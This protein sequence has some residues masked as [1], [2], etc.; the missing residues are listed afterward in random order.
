MEAARELTDAIRHKP[1]SLHPLPPNSETTQ[2][3]S[4]LAE[5]FTKWATQTSPPS[6]PPSAPLPRVQ[7]HVE[8]PTTLPPVSTLPRSTPSPPRVPN[9]DKPTPPERPINKNNRDTLLPPHTKTASKPP[10]RKTSPY[11]HPCDIAKS[12]RQVPLRRPTHNRNTRAATHYNLQLINNVLDPTTGQQQN[13]K[14]LIAPNSPT[15]DIWL[16]SMGNEIG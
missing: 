8:P 5:I 7:Q 4:K 9:V 13:Y 3:I 1:N 16:Q 6:S 2:A 14:Q 12:Y 11:Y 10:T 15:R